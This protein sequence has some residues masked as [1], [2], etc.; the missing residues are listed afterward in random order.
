[1]SPSPAVKGLSELDVEVEKVKDEKKLSDVTSN[2]CKASLNIDEVKQEQEELR[3]LVVRLEFKQRKQEPK[4]ILN[5]RELFPRTT[6]EMMTN[7][8]NEM[9]RWS[10]MKAE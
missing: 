1:M 10:Q 8:I 7:A 3:S 9:P 2:G 4:D 6:N 5:K